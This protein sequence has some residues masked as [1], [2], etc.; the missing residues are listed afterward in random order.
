MLEV[1]DED[2]YIMDGPLD[3]TCLFSLYKKLAPLYEHLV[4][5][6]LIP[7]RPQDLGDAEDVFEKRLSMIFYY[8][9]PLNRFS[10]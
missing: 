5:P 3:L 1:K 10:Q 2:V 8:I 4:Y 7:Q 6:A 9:I